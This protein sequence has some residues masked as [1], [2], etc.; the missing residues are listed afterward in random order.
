MANSWLKFYRAIIEDSSS[1]YPGPEV[2]LNKKTKEVLF[3]FSYR[4]M[5]NITKKELDNIVSETTSVFHT[6]NPNIEL[7]YK[8]NDNNT[9][10]QG[11]EQHCSREQEIVTT[12]RANDKEF[13]KI[14]RYLRKMPLDGEIK[15]KFPRKN[16]MSFIYG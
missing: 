8:K 1:R 12:Y 3:S 6:F 16:A 2:K 7:R 13:E 15:E 9:I 5:C 4:P 11:G 14:K 10:G